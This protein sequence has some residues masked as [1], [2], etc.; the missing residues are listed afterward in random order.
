MSREDNLF[1]NTWTILYWN[2]SFFYSVSAS[3][4]IPATIEYRRY[5]YTTSTEG[6]EIEFW[7]ITNIFSSFLGGN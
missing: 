4:S 6:V 5:Q 3:K 2:I 7:P 1:I